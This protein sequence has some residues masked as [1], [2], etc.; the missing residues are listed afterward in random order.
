MALPVGKR[1]LLTSALTK[2]TLRMLDTD[3]IEANG[4]K[5]RFAQWDVLEGE[6]GTIRLRN[7]ANP[8]GFL[9]VFHDGRLHRGKGGHL[10]CFEV[11]EHERGVSLRAVHNKCKKAHVGV[12]RN[13]KAK[14]AK[15]TRTGRGGSFTPEVVSDTPKDEVAE[16]AGAFARGRAG[17][18]DEFEAHIDPGKKKA[19]LIGC[20]YPGTNAALR[21]CVND[22]FSM[23]ELLIDVKGFQAANIKVLIDTDKS[24]EQPT[25]W[26][27]KRALKQLVGGAS[28]GD[29]IFVHFSGHGTQVPAE[30]PDHEKDRKDEAIVPTDM[31]LIIDDDLRR[32]F[33]DLAH[34]VHATVVTDCCHSGGMLDHKEVQIGQSSREVQ[35]AAELWGTRD[36]EQTPREVSIDTITAELASRSGHT[37]ETTNVRRSLFG[38]FGQE[39]GALCTEFVSVFADMTGFLHFDE[40]AESEDQEED[41]GP[42][43]TMFSSFFGAPVAQQHYTPSHPPPPSTNLLQL[44]GASD[45]E[46]LFSGPL[47]AT[48]APIPAGVKPDIDEQ[49]SDEKGVLICG[50]Q[51]HQTSADCMPGGDPTKAYGALTNTLTTLVKRDPS[52]SAEELVATTRKSLARSGFSQQPGL[53]CTDFHAQQPFICP[54][55]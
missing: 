38:L 4:G 20:N 53:E 31:N 11:V 26:N 18:D 30:G 45:P 27:I 51:S 52:I 15:K 54:S 24:Y 39:V 9:T 16:R 7:V 35:G 34:G 14:N 8:L 47:P 50:C 25:G 23:K 36:F 10:S 49:L 22:V 44:F 13:G 19:V 33:E 37:I 5:G 46:A 32:I 1:V 6:G 28:K 12:L 48:P 3:V 55:V 42:E 40:P 21:G 29:V 2:K 17:D 41:F 43:G